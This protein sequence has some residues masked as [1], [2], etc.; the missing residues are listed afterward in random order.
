MLVVDDTVDTRELYAMCLRIEGFTVSEASDGFEALRSASLHRPHVII[1]DLAMPGLDGWQATQQLKA[2]AGTC[3][4]IVLVVTGQV[5][6]A[7]LQ[8]ARDMGADDVLTKPCRPRE[9]IAKVRQFL[10][11]RTVVPGS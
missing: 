10:A 4:A 3:D 2:D 11:A 9:L 1:M 7:D 8:R 6:T 5:V